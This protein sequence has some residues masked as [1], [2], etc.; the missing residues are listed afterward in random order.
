[1]FNKRIVTLTLIIFLFTMGTSLAWGASVSPQLYDP[2]QSGNAEFECEQAGCNAE[3]AYKVD[4][5]DK[6]DPNGDHT[7]EG[8]TISIT[9]YEDED[10]EYDSFD[11]ESDFPVYC[12][13]VSRGNIA[14]V[15]KYPGGALS[16]T[17]LVAPGSYAISHTTFCWDSVDEEPETCTIIVEK[18]INWGRYS[19]YFNDP[20]FY[21]DISVIPTGVFDSFGLG[22]GD[23]KTLSDL[24]PGIYQ[25][26][27][28]L[29]GWGDAEIK[30]VGGGYDDTLHGDT[31]QVE[32]EEGE[33]ITITFIN[34]PPDFVIPE[35]PLG[36]IGS[37]IV[38][39]GVIVA[40]SKLKARPI[41]I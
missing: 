11:W 15:Y 36:V 7:H 28:E 23:S 30:I 32:I 1:M 16:D 26:I 39:M 22:N 3:F 5:W 6:D 25:V 12:I 37:L 24:D 20:T 29:M 13:I 14:N 31:A 40:I 35:T 18:K 4:D 41:S 21:F 8:N 27:E 17:D 9:A 33:T 10:E 19:Y 34:R 2:W 38:M